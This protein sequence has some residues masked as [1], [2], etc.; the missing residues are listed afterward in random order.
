MS[1]ASSSASR[2]APS[3]PCCPLRGVSSST[4]RVGPQPGVGEYR[5]D[6]VEGPNVVRKAVQQYYGGTVGRA[7][8]LVGDL[9]HVGGHCLNGHTISTA[10]PLTMMPPVGGISTVSR[11]GR[12][13]FAP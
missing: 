3:A 7:P 4:N 1:S 2:S 5:R 13:T 12:P 9:E 10:V 8:F 11:L 6:L